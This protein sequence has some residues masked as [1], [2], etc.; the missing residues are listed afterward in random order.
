M[1]ERY[2][3]FDVSYGQTRLPSYNAFDLRAGVDYGQWSLQLYAK[4]LTDERGISQAST[5]GSAAS[6]GAP[7]IYITR[8]R[9]IGLTVTGQL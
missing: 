6:G 4:N 7:I 1:G 3:G 2:S 8:P 9:V 5:G